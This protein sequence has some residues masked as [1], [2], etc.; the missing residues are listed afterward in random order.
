MTNPEWPMPNQLRASFHDRGVH[1]FNG[2]SGEWQLL[3]VSQSLLA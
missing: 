1:G 2:A 3:A